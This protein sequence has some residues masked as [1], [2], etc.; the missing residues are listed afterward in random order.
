MHW[1]GFGGL[2]CFGRFWGDGGG[3]G[4]AFTPG[5]GFE[6]VDIFDPAAPQL[7]GVR[8]GGSNLQVDFFNPS[9]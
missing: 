2:G 3:G 5:T 1:L 6:D 7:R 4:E 9:R 8:T